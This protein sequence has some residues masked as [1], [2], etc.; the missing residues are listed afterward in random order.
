MFKITFKY[1]IVVG[2]AYASFFKMNIHQLFIVSRCPTN[3]NIF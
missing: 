2:I 3:Y 1:Q